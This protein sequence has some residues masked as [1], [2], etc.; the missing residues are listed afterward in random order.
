M[1]TRGARIVDV[2]AGSPAAA[3]GLTAGALVTA[4]GEEVVASGDALVA[5]VQSRPP[6][7]SVTLVFTD[8][9]G[10]TGPLGL[11]SAP[12][13]VGSG[14]GRTTKGPQS[15]A[16]ETA[17]AVTASERYSSRFAEGRVSG[18]VD[19]QGGSP[20]SRAVQVHPTAKRLYSVLQPDQAGAAGEVCTTD[21]VVGDLIRSA[22]ARPFGADGD[23]RRLG[24]LGGV[25]QCLGDD[26]VG[27]DLHRL[28]QPSS[29]RGRAERGSASGG[30]S[31]AT[32]DETTLGQDRRMDSARQ[33]TQLLE[34]AAGPAR[35]RGR[36]RIRSSSSSVEASACAIEA[37]GPATPA[38]AGRRRAG[39][40][41]SAGGSGRRCATIRARDAV[42]S[43][44]NWALSE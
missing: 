23:L 5:A 33:I 28:G 15:P 8:T 3:A 43:A 21:A 36:A 42:S 25:G 12:I 10:N 29:R 44:Y 16:S 4:V 19:T 31:R 32:P 14:R 27:A 6:G 7:T 38:A 24:V 9:S 34:C 26:V 30:S 39:L 40:A 11:A 17:C 1:S 22:P 2:T 37:P 35:W 18:S 13:R 20:A 41:R